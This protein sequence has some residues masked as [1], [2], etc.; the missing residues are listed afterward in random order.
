MKA[1]TFRDDQFTTQLDE[2]E[3]KRRDQRSNQVLTF[4]PNNDIS[5]RISDDHGKEANAMCSV[6]YLHV[7]ICRLI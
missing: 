1:I 4:N 5:G 7:Y 2:A 6:W 3:L